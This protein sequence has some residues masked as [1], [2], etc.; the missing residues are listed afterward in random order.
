L[1]FCFYWSEPIDDVM[2]EYDRKRPVSHTICHIDRKNNKSSEREK[3][4]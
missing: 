2:I 3:K 1:L 4:Q